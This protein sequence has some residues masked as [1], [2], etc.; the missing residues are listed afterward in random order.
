M[1]KNYGIHDEWKDLDKVND[2][3]IKAIDGVIDSIKVNGE[4]AGGGGGDFS[5]ATVEIDNTTRTS[6][7]CAVPVISEEQQGVCKALARITGEDHIFNTVPLYK[8]KALLVFQS[9]T[10]EATGAVDKLGDIAYIVTGDAT[11]TIS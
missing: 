4:E 3:D 11:F 9:G 7:N 5:T 10:I 1:V 8:G 6:I 2:I